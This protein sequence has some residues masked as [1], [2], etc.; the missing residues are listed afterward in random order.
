ME[1]R[2]RYPRLFFDANAQLEHHAFAVVQGTRDDLHALGYTPNTAI[3]VRFTFVQEDAG[4]DGQSDALIFHGRIVRSV[5]FGL[6]LQADEAGV[7]WLSDLDP[8]EV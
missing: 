1:I 4:V 6:L 5:R 3:G 8:D 7:R 2:T